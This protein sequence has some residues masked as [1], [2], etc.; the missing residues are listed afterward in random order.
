MENTDT[1]KYIKNKWHVYLKKQHRLKKQMAKK[2]K[3]ILS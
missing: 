3:T 1:F 2:I